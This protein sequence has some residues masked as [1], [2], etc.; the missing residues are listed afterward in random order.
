M[1]AARELKGSFEGAVLRDQPWR[2]VVGYRQEERT[3][4]G[5]YV[6][7]I[8]S[9]RAARGVGQTDAESDM[10]RAHD[11]EGE[12]TRVSGTRVRDYVYHRG[13]ARGATTFLLDDADPVRRYGHLPRGLGVI[14]LVADA[15]SDRF[16]GADIV[17]PDTGISPGR[18]SCARGC[19]YH[20]LDQGV[21]DEPG[22]IG[23]H[24]QPV[25]RRVERLRGLRPSE[26]ATRQHELQEPRVWAA[27]APAQIPTLSSAFA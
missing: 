14:N 6:H 13:P 25:Q 20:V 4:P 18:G 22:V 1:V 3:I 27:G 15:E 17:A 9:G 12:C 2:V 11:R 21:A 10:V 23:L 16:L 24:V 7:D 5:L 19:A 8:R 26:I